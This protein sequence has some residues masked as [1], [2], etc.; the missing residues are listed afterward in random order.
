MVRQILLLALTLGLLAGMALAHGGNEHISGT[1]TAIQNDHVTLKTADGKTVTLMIGPSTKYFRDKAAAA[2]ADMV[3][4]TRVVIDAKMD[5]KMKMYN[6]LEVRLG[7]VA[8]AGK[9]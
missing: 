9:K 3:I 7:V 4:G 6:A 5:P 2:K 1:V 8:A